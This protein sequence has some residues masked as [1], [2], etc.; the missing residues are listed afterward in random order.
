MEGEELLALLGCKNETNQLPSTTFSSP[1][2]VLEGYDVIVSVQA[3]DAAAI[4]RIPRAENE[5]LSSMAE[6]PTE[7]QSEG[8]NQG[9][10]TTSSSAQPKRRTGTALPRTARTLCEVM[11]VVLSSATGFEIDAMVKSTYVDLFCYAELM[12]RSVPGGR[13]R[14]A[15]VLVVASTWWYML[16]VLEPQFL[17]RVG[18]LRMRAARFFEEAT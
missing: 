12:L 14:A 5:S 11:F 18:T 10:R 6:W 7:Q 2:S 13:P 16:D 9:A 4:H 17:S 15:A 8:T 1:A 3:N